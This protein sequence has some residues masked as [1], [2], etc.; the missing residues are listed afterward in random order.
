[1]SIVCPD[2]TEECPQPQSRR[3]EDVLLHGSERW[4]LVLLA[5][6]SCPRSHIITLDISMNDAGVMNCLEPYCQ[7]PSN[8]N[9]ESLFKPV[10]RCPHLFH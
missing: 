6:S 10:A 3:F 7:F 2:G 5:R 9:D 1:M 4:Q 8:G